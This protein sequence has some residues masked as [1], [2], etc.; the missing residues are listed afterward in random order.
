M[1]RPGNPRRYLWLTLGLVLALAGGGGLACYHFSCDR[2][3]HAAARDG[4]VMLWM[5]HEFCLG[6]VAYAEILRL[7]QEHSAVCAQHCEGVRAARTRLAEAQAGG[8]AAAVDAAV[9]E[10]ARTEAVC[11]ASTEAY[12]RRVAAVMEPAQGARYLGMVLP[13]LSALD[14]EGPPNPH[15]QR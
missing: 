6:D 1:T 11:R 12:V 14:H 7:H 5:R 9:L 4:D 13:R 10:L 8:D 15:L 2:T 3:A